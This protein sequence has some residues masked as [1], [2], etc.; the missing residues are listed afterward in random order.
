MIRPTLVRRVALLA[1]LLL[2]AGVVHAVPAAAAAPALAPV[3]GL[4]LKA[5]AGFTEAE[6]DGGPGNTASAPAQLP[7]SSM[8]LVATVTNTGTEPLRDVSVTVRVI[9]NG[10]IHGETGSQVFCT[11]TDTSDEAPAPSSAARQR[12]EQS[13]DQATWTY[14]PLVLDP[15]QKLFCGA[16]IDRIWSGP[17]HE[18]VTTAAATGVTSGTTVSADDH[19]WAR[20]YVPE[21]PPWEAPAPL[22]VGD[23]VWLDSDRDGLQDLGEPGIAGVRLT[24]DGPLGATAPDGSPAGPQT[25]DQDGHYYFPG[26]FPPEPP[27]GSDHYYTV[28]LDPGSPALK[29]LMPTRAGVGDDERRDSSTGSASSSSTVLNDNGLDFG[30]VPKPAVGLTLDA[31][32]TAVVGTTFTVG[33]SLTR[34]GKP[35]S[36]TA[37]LELKADGRTAWSTVA[38]V[39]STVGGALSA[40]VTAAAS[41]SYRYHY[42]GDATTLAGTSPER[43]VTIRKAVVALTAAAPP[44]V[45]RGLGVTVTGTITR[46]GTAFPTSTV[47]EFSPDGRT[48]ARVAE[49]RSTG[50]GALSA[51]VKPTRTGSYRYRFTGSSTTEPGTSPARQVFV[52]ILPGGPPSV[53][54]PVR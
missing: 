50:T 14:P 33:G 36:G 7:G 20:S 51:S 4:S 47:L 10:N 37:V 2:G 34:A 11:L 32:T 31:P 29:G 15:G 17:L 45:R 21:P 5:Q 53:P 35:L 48:W 16:F 1:A 23:L 3:T 8:S 24:V 28:T 30:F 41:G 46:E 18:D 52:Q 54:P 40:T 27:S 39:R 25:T 13:G 26:I 9:A 6:R 22:G 38:T 49:V 43:H 19:T 44:S 42:A 12:V